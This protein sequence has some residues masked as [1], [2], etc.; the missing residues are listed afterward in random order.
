MQRTQFLMDIEFA[1]Q[2][3]YQLKLN[4]C[5][6][7]Q[8]CICELYCIPSHNHQ[9]YYLQVY[10]ITNRYEAIYAKTIVHDCLGNMI[11]MY[12]FHWTKEAASRPDTVGKIVCGCSRLSE[13]SSQRLSCI[14]ETLPWKSFWDTDSCVVLDGVWQIIRQWDHGILRRE[15]SG[16]TSAEMPEG[17]STELWKNLWDLNKWIEMDIGGL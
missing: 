1:K 12:P 5:F 15:F 3:I 16:C 4:Q 2:E 17:V 10:Q 13:T 8:D 7:G 11:K 14:L 9:A 6:S